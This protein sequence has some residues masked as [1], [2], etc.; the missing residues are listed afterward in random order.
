MGH[1]P[2]MIVAT[3]SPACSS[4]CL[5]VAHGHGCTCAPPGVTEACVLHNMYASACVSVWHCLRHLVV[6]STLL[7]MT[8]YIVTI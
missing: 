4:H 8:V 7:T 3:T 1:Q 2:V 5:A 6:A